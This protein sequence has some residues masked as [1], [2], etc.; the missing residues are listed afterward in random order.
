M[1]KPLALFIGLRFVRARKS[2]Q[3]MSFVSWISMLGIALGVLALIIVLSVINASTSTMREET[4]KAVPHASLTLAPEQ[5]WRDTVTRLSQQPGVTGA[6]PYLEAQAWLRFEGQ[7]E[8]INVRGVD[9]AIE[10]QVLQSEHPQLGYLL[11]QLQQTPD[12]II[13]GTRLA[14]ALGLFTDQ[15]PSVTPLASLIN[16]QTS[17]ARSFR[18]LGVADFGFYDNDRIALVGLQA[19]QSLFAADA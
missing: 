10:P 18:V 1:H 6:A 11:E 3:L 12:G 2:S 13:L 19:A 8:F 15:Q 14:S 4:L 9:P 17:E 5:S 16:R 7:G